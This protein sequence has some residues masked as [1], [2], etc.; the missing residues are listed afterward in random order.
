MSYE[1]SAEKLRSAS[2]ALS[3]SGVDPLEAVLRMEQ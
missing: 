3:A 2:R 1:A